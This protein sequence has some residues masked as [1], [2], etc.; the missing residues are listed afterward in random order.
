MTDENG[1]P[2]LDDDGKPRTS[3]CFT[4]VQVHAGKDIPTGTLRSIQRQMEAA[5]GRGWLL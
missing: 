2:E 1:R 3:I 5:F 4:S